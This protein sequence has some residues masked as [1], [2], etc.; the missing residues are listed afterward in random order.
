MSTGFGNR[1]TESELSNNVEGEC[2]PLDLYGTPNMGWI[3]RDRVWTSIRI[4]FPGKADEHGHP[5]WLDN[6]SGLEVSFR[7]RIPS[8][9]IVPY[10]I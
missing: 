3:G 4:V 1:E 6:L 10:H 8:I 7:V 2:R 5:V 9:R